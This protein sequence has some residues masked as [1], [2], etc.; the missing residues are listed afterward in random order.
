MA[1]SQNADF[2]FRAFAFGVHVLRDG[3]NGALVKAAFAECDGLEMSLD[4]KTI[5]AGGENFRQIKL[6]GPA[7]YGTLTLK[8]GMTADFGLWEW[9]ASYARLDG[10]RSRAD[11]EVLIYDP[12]TTQSDGSERATL[13]RFRLTRCLPLKV[14]APALNAKD[15]LV[16]IEEC[17]IAYES[18]ELVGA[19]PK[20]A[21]PP[22]SKDLTRAKLVE[23]KAFGDKGQQG[24]PKVSGDQGDG[25]DVTTSGQ[26]TVQF[27]P[28]S[29]KISYANQIQTDSGEKKADQKGG[30]AIQHVGAGTT[31][32]AVTLVFDVTA[33]SD[34]SKGDVRAWTSQVLHFITPAEDPKK[35]GTFIPPA[36]RFEWGMYWFEGIV[37]GVEETLELFSADGRALRATVA[38]TMSQQRIQKPTF[39]TDT[40][41]FPGGAD[42]QP[43]LNPRVAARDGSTAQSLARE[44][45]Q[46]MDW[47]AIARANGVENPRRIPPGTLLDMRV[48]KGR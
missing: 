33:S 34:G 42:A 12:A 28:D 15:G 5:R 16:A 38:L 35:K 24:D 17:Q 13:A 8:R 14:K 27:N 9:V 22:G 39:N 26:L 31:K 18:L 1:D 29:L 19:D 11:V 41:A 30:P 6:L 44:A 3:G 21:S 7:T 45:G 2:V 23:L 20:G 32:L 4:L 43:G 25:G 46:P 40:A 10:M 48:K 47:A 36:T 37:E